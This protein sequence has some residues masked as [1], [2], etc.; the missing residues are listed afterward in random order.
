[1][2]RVTFFAYGKKR[3]SLRGQ[4]L[5]ILP[6]DDEVLAT[7]PNVTEYML[8]KEAHTVSY[9]KSKLDPSE[10]WTA[11]FVTG[12]KYK[13]SWGNT[14]IDFEKMRVTLSE[15]WEEDDLPVIFVHN[16]T[17]ARANFTVKT[18]DGQQYLN[19]TIPST[20]LE[21]PH[22]DLMP[23]QWY[24]YNGSE[25]LT[26]VI[27]GKQSADKYSEYVIN[28]E[29]IRKVKENKPIEEK[30]TEEEIRFWSDPKSWPNETLPKFNDSVYVESGWNMVYDLVEP[31]PIF[32]YVEI[33]GRL[34]FKS[35]QDHHFRAKVI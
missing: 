35:D 22:P 6:W 18:S 12:H 29:G 8:D 4:P 17:D 24:F 21:N 30:E 28:I 7:K 9:W 26:W 32:A 3:N 25:L 15:R 1:M 27:N 23:G 13:L 19:N 34:E 2:R 16:Y 11:V 5:K 20:D 33:N 31:S 10:A 14:G